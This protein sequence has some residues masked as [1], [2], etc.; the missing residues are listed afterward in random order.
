MRKV[1]L[2]SSFFFLAACA[3]D[4]ALPGDVATVNG[5]GISFQEL[6]SRRALLFAGVSPKAPGTD[7]ATLQNQYR[8]VVGKMVEEAVICQFM[9]TQ[10]AALEEG[11]V[12]TEEK[13]I[14]DDYPEGAF[15]E[16]LAEQ[17]LNLENWRRGMSRRLL[18]DQFVQQILRPE[19]VITAEEVQ[20][21]YR[22]H[23]EEFVI[24]E[25]W[26][27]LQIGGPVR[28]DVELARDSLIAGKGPEAAQK[29]FLVAIHDIRMGVDVLPQDLLDLL[30]P[31]KTLEA[32]KPRNLEGEFRVLLLMD[33]TP[34]AT[35]DAAEISKRVE[36]ALSEEKMRAL[37]A[38]WME[39]H[40]AKAD[41]R[42]SPVFAEPV[43]KEEAVKPPAVGE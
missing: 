10:G 36:Q 29:E 24:P 43:A 34:A 2:A 3:Q 23:N 8:Y 38:A 11:A 37:Y 20:Q 40:L 1:L 31:L 12:E 39:K 41:I 13:R 6:E 18:I 30:T 14:R 32:S 19:I 27:F 9:E 16:I 17:G 22:R 25:Q 15:D 33:K 42:I 28:K 35:M 26:H 5:Q 21:Y 7:D 4:A